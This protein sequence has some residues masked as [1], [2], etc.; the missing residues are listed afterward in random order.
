M[1]FTDYMIQEDAGQAHS[2]QLFS[3]LLKAHNQSLKNLPTAYSL[4]PPDIY[5]QN[6]LNYLIKVYKT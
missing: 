4:K 5:E 3:H 1:V 6:V 2:W